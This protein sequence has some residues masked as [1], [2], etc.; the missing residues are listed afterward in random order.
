MLYSIMQKYIN[1]NVHSPTVIKYLNITKNTQTKNQDIF[2]YLH[3]NTVLKYLEI[4][5]K[6]K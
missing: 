5:K 2:K 6:Q 3:S 1:K 4:I